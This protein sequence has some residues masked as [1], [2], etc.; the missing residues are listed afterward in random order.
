MELKKIKEIIDAKLS[1]K[2][3][4]GTWYE[5]RLKICSICE[6]NSVNKKDLSNKEIIKVALNLGKNTCLACGCE[7]A[8]K[9]SVRSEICGLNTIGL[10]PKWLSLPE[11]EIKVAEDFYIENLN[12]ELINL[13]IEGSFIAEYK[14]LKFEQPSTF[15]LRIKSNNKNPINNFKAKAG[16]GCTTTNIIKKGDS[17]YVDISYNTK[18]LGKFEKNLVFNFKI[19]E[20]EYSILG[21][22]KGHVTR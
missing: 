14:N 7:I 13:T 11:T 21:K 9:T 3:E 1:D 17:Y 16:C 2:S 18:I 15:T 19:K 20:K 8:A 22:I 4:L 6:Y 5:D 12:P 10:P